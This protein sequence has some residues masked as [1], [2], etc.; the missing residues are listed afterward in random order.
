MHQI[1]ERNKPGKGGQLR[2]SIRAVWV[3]LIAVALVGCYQSAGDAVE[4][5]TVDLA[6]LE[7]QYTPTAIPPT[8]LPTLED[9]PPTPFITPLPS[10]GY[11]PPTDTPFV[12]PTAT[13]SIAPTDPPPA[14]DVL[15]TLEPP[16]ELPP[17]QTVDPAQ[18][19]AVDLGA[20]TFTP[21]LS[22]PDAVT[23]TT[24]TPDILATPTSFATANPCVYTVQAGD[25]MNR[26]AQKF[27]VPLD[28]LIA[29]N[30]QLPNA[31]SLQVGDQ[32][33]IPNCTAQGTGTV[34]AV[35]VPPTATTVAIDG[36]GAPTA[37]MVSEQDY[38]TY[39]IIAGDTLGLI[40][41]K[42]DTSVEELVRI[43]NLPNA[44]VML[45]IGQKLKVP[46]N[47]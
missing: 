9:V 15:P 32:V 13:D 1:F 4:P 27:S 36:A 35:V 28:V 40:A 10:E 46:R 37:I 33:N 34:A 45:S 26:I 25:W 43:N 2:V 16:I 23:E 24:A 5:T 31:N 29:A 30:T 20:P 12:P 39:T 6:V 47:N 7:S 42:Y 21:T 41:T 11:I 17:T 19:N 3:L 38:Q 14:T 22:I 44:E 18:V 8:S